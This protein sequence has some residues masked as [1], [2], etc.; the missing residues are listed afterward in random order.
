MTLT[1]EWITL[2]LLPFAAFLGAK[3][4]PL[5]EKK[6]NSAMAEDEDE[7]KFRHE[8]EE[9]RVKAQEQIALAIERIDKMLSVMQFQIAA[10]ERHVGIDGDR[11][12]IR[13]R[14]E[15]ERGE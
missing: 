8:M 6:A 10:I 15:G 3:V 1:P 11:K 9:R 13:R 4:W 14:T 5:L 7:R 12:P 2:I